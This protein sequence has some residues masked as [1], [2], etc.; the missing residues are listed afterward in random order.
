M[1]CSLFTPGSRRPV[2]W[3]VR[4]CLCVSEL[5][6]GCPSVESACCVFPRSGWWFWFRLLSFGYPFQVFFV[7]A[8]G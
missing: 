1:R 4:V 6:S 5:L 8:L 7:Y 3:R 2:V